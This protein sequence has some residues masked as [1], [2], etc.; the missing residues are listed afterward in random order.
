MQCIF[1]ERSI[2]LI[3]SLLM[4]IMLGGYFFIN[5]S[6]IMCAALFLVFFFFKLKGFEVSRPRLGGSVD[7]S[8]MLIDRYTYK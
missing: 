8:Q 3:D 5:L 6:Q 1:E 2:I 7:I 4:Q